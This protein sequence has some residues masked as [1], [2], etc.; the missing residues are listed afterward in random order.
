M[1]AKTDPLRLKA[2]LRL[3]A[4]SPEVTS[5]ADVWQAAHS[6]LLAAYDE[7]TKLH[8]R[9][10][11]KRG[12][13]TEEAETSQK[14]I[15]E[16]GGYIKT[17]FVPAERAARAEYDAALSDYEKHARDSLAEDIES[18]KASVA[19]CFAQLEELLGMGSTLHNE[20][21]AAGIDLDE[22]LLTGASKMARL[23]APLKSTVAKWSA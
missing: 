22:Q 20:A 12:I 19:G 9:I 1:L 18:F 5:A 21:I 13:L 8:E 11:F 3:P 10:E 7:R 17:R 4:P 2:S 6:A 14:R 16:I 23:L 15:A